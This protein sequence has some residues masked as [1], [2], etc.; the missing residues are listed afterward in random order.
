MINSDAS[1]GR[2]PDPFN[3]YRMV[4]RGDHLH[5]GYWP[6]QCCGNIDAADGI[7]FEDAQENMFNQ[8][9]AHFPEPPARVL[10]VGCGLGFSAAFLAENGYQ[11]TAIAPSSELI[12]YAR[13]KY[14]AGNPAFFEAGFLDEGAVFQG[15][16]YDVILFQESFQYLHPVEQVILHAK[17]LL[18]PG[19]ILVIGDEICYNQSIKD[20][21]AVHLYKDVFTLLEE[22]G[23]LTIFHDRIGKHVQS[24]CDHLIRKFTEH[25][26][27]IVSAL[28][29]LGVDKKEGTERLE[30]FLN[31]WKSQK[32]WYEAGDMGYEIIVARPDE[33][34]VRPYAEGDEETILPE[35][36]AVFVA[37]RSM[38]HWNWKFRTNPYCRYKIAEVRRVADDKLAAHY[39]GY[40]VPWY[41]S[42]FEPGEFLSYQIGD[43]W[44]D[45]DFRES[46]QKGKSGVLFRVVNYFYNKYCIDHVPFI[47]GYI[48]GKHRTLGARILEYEYIS[49]I[50][51]HVLDFNT[52]AMPYPNV[53]KR[54]INGF[55]VEKVTSVTDEYDR[56]FEMVCDDYGT[57]VKRSSTYLKWR[58]LDCPDKVHHM[59]AVRRFGKL[60]GW[61]VFTVNGADLFWGDA[62]FVKK[63]A[64]GADFLLRY[65]L[66]FVYPDA[67]FVEGWFSPVPGWWTTVL[68]KIGFESRPEPSNLAPGF[69][70]FDKR[71]TTDFFEHNVYYTKGD[72][73]LF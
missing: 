70:V 49:D 32:K 52:V 34:L 68:R 73:D 22:S 43:I 21:T 11:V 3:F 35:F 55:T 30:F 2:L 45:S 12:D 39:C 67:R 9:L 23:F 59:Y 46:S 57:L 58:Y 25:F 44:V 14:T 50:A 26:D 36:N 47:Y 37:N 16:Q 64:M 42:L 31:G 71:Y 48:T 15:E 40:P 61:G 13:G 33:F 38:D 24:T 56:L 72:S 63:H 17:T 4:L 28:E 66:K 6:D 1:I 7:S 19:G 10:D 41:S 20:K 69:K 53:V 51:Y 8:L 62:L 27:P 54:L 65:L 18:A 60:T 29:N 5:F